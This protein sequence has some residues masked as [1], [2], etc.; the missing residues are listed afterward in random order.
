[1]FTKGNKVYADTYKYLHHKTKPAI[2]LTMIGDE[3][4]FYEVDMTLPVAVSVKGNVVTWENGKLAFFSKSMNYASIKEQLVKSRYTNDEQL[5]IMLNKDLSD[6]GQLSYERMQDWRAFSE[7]LARLVDGEGYQALTELEVAKEKKKSEILRYD[8]SHHVNSFQIEGQDIWIDKATRVG[9]KLRF[10]AE[11][12]LGRAETTLWQEGKH[13]TLPLTGNVTALDMLDGIELY[14]SAC[15]DN[16][17]RH[18]SVVE[19]LD[20]VESIKSYDYTEGYPQKLVF[21]V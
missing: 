13:F 14:A 12:R 21:N 2:G 7:E 5:A 9:L 19:S 20:S 10:E 15:Y 8:S 6:E 17:Q 3:S 11:Q 18:L 4:D 16:T 1:M